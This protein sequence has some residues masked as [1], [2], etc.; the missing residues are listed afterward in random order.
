MKIRELNIKNF[1][2]GNVYGMSGTTV[3][4]NYAYLHEEMDDNY[5]INAINIMN[6]GMGSIYG[7]YSE[8]TL[9]GCCIGLTVSR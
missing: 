9:Y 6:K 4:G 1:G 8:A 2:N 7:M 5:M 3:W